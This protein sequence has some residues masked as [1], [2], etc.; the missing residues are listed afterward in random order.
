[1]N[2]DISSREY[3]ANP[4][5][6]FARMRAEAPVHRMILPD[7]R[8][9]WL[10]VHYDEVAATLKDERFIKDRFKTPELTA[11][12]PWMPKS[13]LPLA[14]NMLDQDPP[15][16]TRLRALVHKG[17]TPRLIEEMRKRVQ[18]LTDEFLDAKTRAGNMDLIHDYALPL[19]ST[20]IAEMLGVPAEDRHRF[21]RW[22]SSMVSADASKLSLYRA[23]PGALA[24]I[25]YVRKLVK[26]RRADPRDDLTSA[27]VRAEEAGDQLSEDEMV[28]MIVLLLIAGHETTVNLIANGTLALLAHP[29][30]ME[31][32]R[33]DPGMIQTAVEELLRYDGPLAMAT[34]RFARE[35][36]NLGGTTI[37][38]N[39]LAF[40]VLG[41]ANRDERQFENPDALDLAR[42]ENKHLAFGL[43]IHYCLGAPLARLEGQIAINTL[44]RRTADLR[45]R[46]PREELRWRRGLMLRGVEELPVSFTARMG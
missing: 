26:K 29:E 1:M 43:G 38:R 6:F 40:A 4:Y 15:A 20:I 42:A 3:K 5:P 32:L 22:S 9:A 30:Q 16:H 2:L 24:F 28:A 21:H 44:L 45:L 14:H 23:M 11:K 12:Q 27:L 46:V 7:K 10:V 35:D 17:F 13:F 37:P 25:R 41:S 36:V 19:P 18:S 33:K 34:E 31:M 39:G 8:E